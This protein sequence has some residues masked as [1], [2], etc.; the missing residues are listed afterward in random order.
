MKWI[1]TYNTEHVG[2]STLSHQYRPAVT[3]KV[4]A[5][6]WGYIYTVYKRGV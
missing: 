2:A 3:P 4:Y 6:H 1:I 5:T